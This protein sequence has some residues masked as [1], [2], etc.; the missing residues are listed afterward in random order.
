AKIGNP[1]YVGGQF[2]AIAPE[3]LPNTTLPVASAIPR[4]YLFA[5]DATTGLPIWSFGAVVDG[6]VYALEVDPG[7][8]TLYVGG[9]FS[10][11][12]GTALANFAIL[13]ATTGALKD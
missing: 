2:P 9:R 5:A 13:D 11:V 3:R 10:T 4:S 8:N 1:L 6:P 12:D 7:T